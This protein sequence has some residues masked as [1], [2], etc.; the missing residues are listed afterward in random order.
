[1]TEDQ[2]LPTPP[3]VLYHVEDWV[4]MGQHG[5]GAY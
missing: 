5:Q 1:L 3:K 2:P 4:W